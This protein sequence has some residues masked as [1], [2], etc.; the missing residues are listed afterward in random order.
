MARDP[1][2]QTRS[3]LYGAARGLGWLQAAR[4]GRVGRRTANV[5]LGRMATR[6]IRRLTKG[7]RI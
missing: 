1:V 6:A 2:A 7:V 4:K 5:A 3:A